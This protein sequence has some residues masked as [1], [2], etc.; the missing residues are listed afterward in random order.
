MK[1]SDDINKQRI[2]ERL[3]DFW[4][5]LCDNHIIA[6]ILLPVPLILFII[7]IVIRRYYDGT[8]IGCFIASI[9]VLL[10]VA[11]LFAINHDD[12]GI[13]N[14]GC[15]SFGVLVGFL[16]VFLSV[17]LNIEPGLKPKITYENQFRNEYILYDQRLFCYPCDSTYFF[18]SIAEEEKINRTDT[19]IIC[20]KLYK[21]HF[22][23]FYKK[24][25]WQKIQETN[26]ILYW[27]SISYTP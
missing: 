5:E 9:I 16:S 12:E 20:N 27:N 26:E 10:F 23:K 3:G 2:K 18:V 25:E 1:H 11:Y 4:D 17:F 22:T 14:P 8:G 6:W 13:D 15:T 24:E 19:C 21:H 7:S